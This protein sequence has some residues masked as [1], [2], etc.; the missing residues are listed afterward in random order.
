[1]NLT[2]KRFL[3]LVVS[4]FC[5]H[6][7]FS[8]DNY[9]ADSIRY[10]QIPKSTKAKSKSD[11]V[12]PSRKVEYFFNVQFGSLVGCNDCE[13]GKDFTFSTATQHGVLIGKKLRT[14][15]GIGFDSYLNW[16]T[17][18]LYASASWDLIGNRNAN[19]VYVQ[20]N[21]GWAHPW[22]VRTG[23]YAYYTSDP[24]TSVDG[25]RMIN[26]QIGYRIKYYDLRIALSLGYKYQQINYKG[27]GYN[28]CAACDFPQSFDITQDINRF[29]MNMVLGWK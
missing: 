27:F 15:L 13:Q 23:Q 7:A 28:G 26:P 20:L 11:A 12:V 29:Q 10:T 18:P 24:F 5:Y 19:S 22:F 25:G 16:Q 1:M 3:L 8:Q 17:L 21:Y 14:S 6:F 4:G 9:E 2:M